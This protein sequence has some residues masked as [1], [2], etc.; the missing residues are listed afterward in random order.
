MHPRCKIIAENGPIEI[1]E[2]NIFEEMVVIINKSKDVMKIG[3]NNIFEVGSEVYSS[4]IGDNNTIEAKAFVS[5][6]TSIGN[7]CVIGT[8]VKIPCGEQIADHTIVYGPTNSTKKYD[9]FKE[10][11]ESLHLS[12]VEILMKTLPKFHKLRGSP[13]SAQK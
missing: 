1:G 13:T 5:E 3:N 6:G 12:H 8:A 10:N 4:K 7:G 11:H 2:N 9:F